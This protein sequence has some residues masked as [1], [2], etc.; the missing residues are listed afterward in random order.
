MVVSDYARITK[1]IEFIAARAEEQPTL[2]EIAA[3]VCL[4]PFHF[5]R[6]FTRWSGVS[7]KRFLQVL[8]VERAK[9]LLRA[10]DLPL[11]EITD[12]VGLSSGSRLHE[13]FVNLEAVTPA[14]FRQRGAGLVIRYG[15]ADTP[16][17]GA[18]VALTAR[19][20]CKLVFVEPE[21]VAQIVTELAAEW[22]R[23]ELREAHDEAQQLLAG[24]FL[25]DRPAPLSLWVRGTN[26]Q[27][28]VWR[29]L[30][31][32]PPGQVVSYTDVAR[33][34]GRP[35]ASRAV[36]SAV[37]HNSVAFLIP[38]HRVIQQN[39]T[40]GGYRWGPERKQAM[41]AWEVARYG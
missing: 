20:I 3:H 26:F 21:R 25:R 11:L 31:R 41:Q 33:A 29:A 39:G 32:I 8:T 37:G 35:K 19:G 30:L 5:Q 38:C 9:R 34:I 23:A 17:G 16:F 28:S 36:G 15:F 24:M 12:A 6:L 7:P 22:P 10:G 13:H 1:A 27:V 14:E 40:L 18:L 4:S 2:E